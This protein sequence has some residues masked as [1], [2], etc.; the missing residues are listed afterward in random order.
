MDPEEAERSWKQFWLA[1]LKEERTGEASPLRG[2]H[3]RS[4]VSKSAGKNRKRK[5]WVEVELIGIGSGRFVS[6]TNGRPSKKKVTR[7][8]SVAEEALEGVWPPQVGP[9]DHFLH[10]LRR[11]QLRKKSRG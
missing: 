3:Y 7:L 8:D 11:R 1:A 4:F 5:K 9:F 2:Y 10:L 6:L